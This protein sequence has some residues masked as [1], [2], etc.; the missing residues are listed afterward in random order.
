MLSIDRDAEQLELLYT[1]GGNAKWYCYFGKQSGS[2]F[3][4]LNIHFQTVVHPRN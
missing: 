4:K 2:F 1:A 3:I